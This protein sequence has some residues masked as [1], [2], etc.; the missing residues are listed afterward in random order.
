MTRN[1]RSFLKLA[2]AAIALSIAPLKLLAEF[3]RPEKALAATDLD[4]VFAQLGTPTDSDQIML[5]S[6]DI[7]ENGA[8]VPVGV[9]SNIPGTSKIYVVIEKNPNPLAAAF[10]IPE[11]TEAF[12]QTRVKVAQTSPIYAVVE[13]GGK[14][15]KTSRETKVTLGGCGG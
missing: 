9:T 3:V 13:A 11:G 15:Y 6:P 12:V 4:G 14:L 10:A 7:A 8:V 1:R 5:E 2:G